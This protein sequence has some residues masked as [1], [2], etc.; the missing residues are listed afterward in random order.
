MSG[1]AHSPWIPRRVASEA[2]LG[3]SRTWFGS[4]SCCCQG[5]AEGEA[6]LAR[7]VSLDACPLA[8]PEPSVSGP[9]SGRVKPVRYAMFLSS[10]LDW[11][12]VKRA[13]A[14]L[15]PSFSLL[16]LNLSTGVGSALSCAWCLEEKD[17]VDDMKGDERKFY[18]AFCPPEMQ[19]VYRETRRVAWETQMS[20]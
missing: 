10:G 2:L 7:S 18:Y 9:F 14:T 6:S 4:A 11:S 12:T 19:T 20:F 8:L 15:W 1:T 3:S 13:S 16:S 17:N 5:P